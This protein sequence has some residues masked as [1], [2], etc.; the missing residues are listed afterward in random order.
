[1]RSLISKLRALLRRHDEKLARRAYGDREGV[2]RLDDLHAQ[3][4][5]LTASSR[6]REPP[7]DRPRP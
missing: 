5:D 1:M 2:E 6:L 4:N 3:R 7:S